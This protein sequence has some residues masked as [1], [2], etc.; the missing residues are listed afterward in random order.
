MPMHLKLS[1][2]TE[3]Y[4][5]K[6]LD[7]KI[8][9][10]T[11]AEFINQAD[12][13]I[14]N[15]GK[16][17][18][19]TANPESLMLAKKNKGFFNIVNNAGLVTADGI[20]LLWAAKFCSYKISNGPVKYLEIFFLAIISLLSAVFYPKYLKSVLPERV[21][22]A[23]FFWD[24]IKIAD[25]NK[26][27]VFLLGGR[28]GVA[29]KVK[30]KVKDKYPNLKISGFYSGNPEEKDLVEKINLKNTDILFVAWGQPRQEK[31]ISENLNNLNINIAIGVGGTF[32]FVSGN[33]K[34]APNFLQKIGLEWFWRLIQEPKRINRI[35]TAVP[36]FIYTVIRYK[37][38]RDV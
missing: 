25:K 11:K 18:L 32:D 23:D 6:I 17:F 24:L 33:I 1:N 16:L 5:I 27:S 35:F 20:G 30:E 8:N 12:N 13:S 37:M 14:K 7:V 10:A 36:R 3:N 19:V 26:K 2:M 15:N 4:F 28:E 31:W 38:K 29:E 21:A 22:G 34:R 9:K